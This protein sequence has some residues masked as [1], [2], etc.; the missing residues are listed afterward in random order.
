MEIWLITLVNLFYFTWSQEDQI[1]KL[2]RIHHA[3]IISS[4][5]EVSK[6]FY[7]DILGLTIESEHYWK[8]QNWHKTDCSLSRTYGI[9]LFSF[10]NLPT[11]I[12]YPEAIGLHHLAFEMDSIDETRKDL[13]QK[14][15][16]HESVQTDEYTKKRFV[17]LNAPDGLPIINSFPH[18]NTIPSRTPAFPIFIAALQSFILYFLI[19]IISKYKINILLIDF[20]FYSEVPNWSYLTN[21]MSRKEASRTLDIIS[22]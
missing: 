14:S 21:K 18:I 17:F 19:T 2:N 7:T 12:S 5:Y 9:E 22:K 1:I 8:E 13:D 10:L 4:D 3:A 20:I 16:T 15:G 6:R 11:R